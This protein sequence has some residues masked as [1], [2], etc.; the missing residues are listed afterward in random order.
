MDTITHSIQG[1]LVYSIPAKLLMM[2][3]SVSC[4]TLICILFI[5]GCIEGAW[6]DVYPWYR[7]KFKSGSRWDGY[8][9]IYHHRVHK[10]LWRFF[11]AFRLHVSVIDS[12]FHMEAGV[13][14]WPELWDMCLYFWVVT[15][16]ALVFLIYI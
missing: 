2:L 3:F 8:Y 10:T 5:W 13:N 4:P 12:Y 15:F 7:W 9:Q 11:P 14:W 6:P 16:L 1:G